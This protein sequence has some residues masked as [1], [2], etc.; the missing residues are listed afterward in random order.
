MAVRG[1][2]ELHVV[3]L[4]QGQQGVQRIQIVGHVAIGRVD[5]CGAAVQDVVA[6]EQ[7]TIFHQQQ[8]KVVGGVA[9][10]VHHLQRMFGCKIDL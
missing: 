8:A 7:Q 6:R 10:C 3:L 5:H 9:R 4:A 2:D 1:Q